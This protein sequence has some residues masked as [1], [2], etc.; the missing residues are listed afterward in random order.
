MWAKSSKGGS[1]L[2]ISRWDLSVCGHMIPGDTVWRGKE[3]TANSEN[4]KNSG[5]QGWTERE[6]SLGRKRGKRSPRGGGKLRECFSDI[7]SQMK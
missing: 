6:R 7:L 2:D 3:G 5:V 1:A 4:P